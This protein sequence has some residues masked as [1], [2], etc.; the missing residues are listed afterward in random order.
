M[1]ATRYAGCLSDYLWNRI[2]SHPPL[3]GIVGPCAAGKSTLIASLRQRGYVVKHIA[4]EHSYVKDM[5][6]RIARPDLLIYLDVSYTV[7]CIRRQMDW[8]EKEY[9]EEIFRLRDAREN[10]DYYLH[11]DDLSPAVVLQLVLVFLQNVVGQSW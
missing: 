5:W 4:Q 9:Q 3:I 8:T 7:S 6:R 1:P 10:A 11:T 2:I